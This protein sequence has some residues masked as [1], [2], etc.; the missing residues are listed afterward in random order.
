MGQIRTDNE[1][2]D[3]SDPINTQNKWLGKEVYNSTTNKPVYSITANPNGQWRDGAGTATN[4]P[5]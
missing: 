3:I 2:N 4:T 1:L 5:V